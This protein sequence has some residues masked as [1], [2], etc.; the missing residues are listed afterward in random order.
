MSVAHR[1]VF[2]GLFF[3]LS[4]LLSADANA[5]FLYSTSIVL[6][7]I[8]PGSPGSI[9]NFPGLGAQIFFPTSDGNTFLFVEPQQRDGYSVPGADSVNLAGIRVSA[10][11]NTPINAKAAFALTLTLVNSGLPGGAGNSSVVL[12]G[13][14]TIT[15]LTQS[16][17]TV[18]TA[19]TS[20]STLSTSAGGVNFVL[21]D[22]TPASPTVNGSDGNIGAIITA[23]VPEPASAA[24]VA[25]PLFFM[26]RRTQN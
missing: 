8:P 10:Q 5:S 18:T 23:S 24:I 9:T 15:N 1:K 12:N 20:P 4:L 22:Y 16:S 26:R 2:C 7:A 17:G 14:I 19:F 11:G 25:L 6:T 21:S 3:I 13:T